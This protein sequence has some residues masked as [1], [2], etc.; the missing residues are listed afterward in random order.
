MG[1]PNAIHHG[2]GLHLLAPGEA[3]QATCRLRIAR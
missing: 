1:L 3:R 2:E